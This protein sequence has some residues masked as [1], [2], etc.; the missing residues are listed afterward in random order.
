M[1]RYA[2]REHGML[3]GGGRG[4]PFLSLVG[5]VVAPGS[6][7]GG[8]VYVAL[9]YGRPVSA[10]D[11]ATGKECRVFTDTE[12][13]RELL[14]RRGVLYVLADDMKAADHNARRRWINQTAPKLRGYQFPRR[15]IRMYGRQRVLALNAESGERLW[16]KACGAAG[17]VL[18]ATLAVADG[19]VCFQSTS[20]VVCLDAGSGREA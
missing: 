6:G 7:Q 3:S 8:R 11:P 5:S 2:G 4:R 12:R 20:H 15:A 10:L 14:Y 9:G 13:A 17:E 19:R 18:P 1:R 16:Q